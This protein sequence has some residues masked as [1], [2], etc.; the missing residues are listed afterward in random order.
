MGMVFEEHRW[1]PRD[2]MKAR[3]GVIGERVKMHQERKKER[4]L[5]VKRMF[6]PDRM[7][8]VNLQVAYEQVVPPDQY[9]IV[10]PE[11]IS[12]ESEMSLPMVEEVLA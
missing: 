10:S 11:H 5:Q 6:E 9:R 2:R 7:A 4:T 3:S 1:P 12:E 8:P